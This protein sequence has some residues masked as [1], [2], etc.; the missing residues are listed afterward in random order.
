MR[1]MMRRIASAGLLAW[2]VCM[3]HAPAGAQPL[4]AIVRQI[5]LQHRGCV[6]QNPREAFRGP[7]EGLATPIV[8]VTYT[9]E[10]CD[11]SNSWR[12]TFGIFHEDRSGRLVGLRITPEPRFV[13][14]TARVENGRI[15]VSGL[16]YGPGD[17]RCCPSIRRTAAYAVR[18]NAAVLSR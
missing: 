18:G 11:G 6:I 5:Q 17:P 8:I 9:Y 16:D 7:V 10:G 14:R 13:V 12:A 2:G 3:L 15:E 4:E 1:E